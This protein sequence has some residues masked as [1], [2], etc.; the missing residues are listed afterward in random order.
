MSAFDDDDFEDEIFHADE[1]DE[2]E[3]TTVEEVEWIG[4]KFRALSVNSAKTANTVDSSCTSS[5]PIAIDASVIDHDDQDLDDELDFH[6][7]LKSLDMLS[8]I[9]GPEWAARLRERNGQL[10]SFDRSH[11]LSTKAADDDDN[12]AEMTAD[13]TDTEDYFLGSAYDFE[14]SEESGSQ[15]N[16]RHT[17]R[18]VAVEQ[19]QSFSPREK[20]YSNASTGEECDDD[21]D[22]IF[23]MDV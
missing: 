11:N 2:E 13:C 8:L 14:V 20:F 16:I 6:M 19:K 9:K 7:E 22:E 1:P 10:P 21:E 18:G 17:P 23:V 12:F 3:Y 5:A 4:H 15:I